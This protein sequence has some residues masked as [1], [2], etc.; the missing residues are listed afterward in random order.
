[1]IGTRNKGFDTGWMN[2][3]LLNTTGWIVITS[4]VL[5]EKKNTEANKSNLVKI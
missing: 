3:K 1:M 5:K 4:G 2:F